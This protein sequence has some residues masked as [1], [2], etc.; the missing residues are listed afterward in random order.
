MPR[1]PVHDGKAQSRDCQP[2]RRPRLRRTVSPASASGFNSKPATQIVPGA[3]QRFPQQ[4]S[5]FDRGGV[6]AGLHKLQVTHRDLRL[7]RQ[8]LLRQPGSRTQP[9]DILAKVRASFSGHRRDCGT[10]EQFDSEACFV[11]FWSDTC[12]PMP[13][14]PHVAVLFFLPQPDG[15]SCPL[16]TATRHD[17]PS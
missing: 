3:V 14:I 4:R 6:A 5:H 7:F 9:A 17:I 15:Q 1:T 12:G 10:S 11:F 13:S 8:H 2:D 16:Q